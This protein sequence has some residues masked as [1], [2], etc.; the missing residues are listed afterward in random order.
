[1]QALFVCIQELSLKTIRQHFS[2]FSCH[3]IF[4]L[5][6]PGVLALSLMDMLLNI[7]LKVI[8]TKNICHTLPPP[9]TP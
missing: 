2:L 5:R 9:P 8:D 4:Y 3:S 7:R 1:M 6:C